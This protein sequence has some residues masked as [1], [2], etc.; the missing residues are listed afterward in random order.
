MTAAAPSGR[1]IIK[2]VF[3]ALMAAACVTVNVYFPAAQVQEVAKEFADGVKQE[4][5]EKHGEEQGGQSSWMRGFVRVASLL[6]PVSVAYAQDATTVSNAVIRGLRSKLAQYRAQLVPYYD[7]GNVGIDS[8][9]MTVL[10][11]KGG[12]GVKDLATVRRL[13]KADNDAKNQLYVEVAKAMNIDPRNVSKIQGI[14]AEQWF[15]IANG[16]WWIQPGGKWKK[17]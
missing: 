14:F 16:G 6:D 17:K 2:A 4:S 8:R 15:K 11:D 9:G 7:A 12:L 3:V 10:R 5:I 13:V 1:L